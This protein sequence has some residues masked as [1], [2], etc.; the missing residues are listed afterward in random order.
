M[1]DVIVIGA[2]VIGTLIARELKKYILD[3]LIL[4]K[5]NDVGNEVSSANSAIVHSGYDPKPN[6]LK[7]VLNVKG[8]AMF[9]DLS[10]ELD[11]E[12]SRIGSLTIAYDDE[13][14]ELL[15]NLK[16]RADEN[17]VLTELLDANET[18]KRE[19]NLA[20]N[21]KGSL[22][23]PS[24]GIVNPF[25]LVANAAEN[26]I[27]NGGQL[28]L[29][30]KVIGITDENSYFSVRTN[31][32]IYKAKVVINAAGLYSSEI[33]SLYDETF[34]YKIT[35]KKGE[36]YLLKKGT[37]LVNHVCF[38]VPS[39]LGKGILMAP[40]TSNNILLGPNNVVASEL[41]DFST[42]SNS[43]NDIKNKVLNNLKV[44]PINQTIRIFAGNRPHIENFDDFY[45]QFS[46]K[47]NKFIN[48]VGIE[49]PGLA[50][51]PAIAEYVVQNFVKKI[52]NLK[53][54]DAFNPFVKKH[55]NPSNL[56]D[57]E[58]KKFIENNPL[59]GKIVCS[60]EKVSE[61]EILDILSRSVP[62]NSIKAIK[63][64]TRAG[65]GTCQGGFCT[66]NI[67]KI[68]SKTK[69]VDLDEIVYNEIGSN[70]LKERAK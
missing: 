47:S 69:N 29:N 15:R 45:I 52:I 26:F 63:K 70:I 34:E 12:F 51:S 65:F 46:K 36:Y 35:P 4:E 18:L 44:N 37:N 48:L 40:T 5:N 31:K 14:L 42:D 6:S 39:R 24:A 53:K 1:F 54:N 66:P 21:V 8:N 9:D 43:L 22:F 30:E 10:K 2:G 67:L 61:G 3:V 28:K 56:T 57:E 60:C 27:D 55:Y 33:A 11:L 32:N 41:D 62:I 20:Q 25:T 68:I 19:P 64:R 58:K 59:Y 7:A 49:S 17:G 38:G 50:S 13:Q 23:A 16:I